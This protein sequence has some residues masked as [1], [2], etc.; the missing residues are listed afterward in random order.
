M[1]GLQV[2]GAT[3]P[4]HTGNRRNSNDIESAV[5]AARSRLQLGRSLLLENVSIMMQVKSP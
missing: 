5:Y 2:S 4:G 1:P 3:G